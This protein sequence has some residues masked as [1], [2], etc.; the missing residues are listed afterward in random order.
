MDFI[1]RIHKGGPFMWPILLAPYSAWQSHLNAC[2]SSCSAPTP[3][4]SW[5]AQKLI[6]ANNIDRAIKLCNAE[7]NAFLPRVLKAGFDPGKPQRD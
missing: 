7:P 6:T 1:R 4:P 5:P 2:T 3:L